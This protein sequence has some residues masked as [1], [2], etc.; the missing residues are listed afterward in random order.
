MTDHPIRIK[1]I[2]KPEPDLDRLVSALLALAIARVEAQ[3]AESA[4][5][6]GSASEEE[7]AR[8]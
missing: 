4:E 6:A 8:D 7:A 3:R 2:R 1:A 5:D